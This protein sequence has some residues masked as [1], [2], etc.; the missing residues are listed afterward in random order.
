MNHKKE[1]LKSLWVN[2]KLKTAQSLS[3]AFS[4]ST[5]QVLDVHFVGFRVPCILH[6]EP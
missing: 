6:P 3:E 4:T 1:L 5:R 2:P